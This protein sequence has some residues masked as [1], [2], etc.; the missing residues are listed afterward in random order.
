MTQVDSGGLLGS[1]FS[2]VPLS[3]R[4]VRGHGERRREAVDGLAAH[5]SRAE[6]FESMPLT[7]ERSWRCRALSSTT[8]MRGTSELNT[9]LLA[10]RARQ[11]ISLRDQ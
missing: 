10:G 4:E 2:G 11:V 6:L 9:E 1:A 5:F 3:A 8:L 7:F